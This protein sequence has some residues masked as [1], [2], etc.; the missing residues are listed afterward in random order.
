M[1]KS[2]SSL[3]A[4][5]GFSLVGSSMTDEDG[6]DGGNDVVMNGNGKEREEVEKEKRGWDWRTGMREGAKG[7]DVLRILRLG[8]AREVARAWVDGEE[9]S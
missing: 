4:S 8:L 2:I 6:A 5:S 9:M 7:N 1:K 3:T